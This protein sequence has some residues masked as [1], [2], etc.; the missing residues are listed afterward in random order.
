LVQQL[1]EEIP[2]QPARPRAIGKSKAEPFADIGWGKI[3]GD[4][5]SVREFD[6]QFSAQT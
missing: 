6:P 2:M 1:A 3:N 5:L 4:A